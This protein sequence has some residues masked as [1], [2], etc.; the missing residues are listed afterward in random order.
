MFTITIKYFEYVNRFKVCLS[1]GSVSA[2]I[3]VH[4]YTGSVSNRPIDYLGAGIHQWSNSTLI[5]VGLLFALH[6][7]C[8]LRALLSTD[9]SL[10]AVSSPGPGRFLQTNTWSIN[11]LL[12]LHLVVFGGPSGFGNRLSK[13]EPMGLQECLI[14]SS[15]LPLSVQTRHKQ[16]KYFF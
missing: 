16:T 11:H 12:F 1:R 15:V 13:T 4:I 3:W 2:E 9:H 14:S 10:S 8:L 6:Q 7:S 5:A